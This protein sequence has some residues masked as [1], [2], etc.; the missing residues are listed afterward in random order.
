[1]IVKVSK[2]MTS[3]IRKAVKPYGYSI[4]LEKVASAIY[5]QCVDFDLFAHEKDYDISSNSFRVIKVVYPENMYAM[6]RYITSNDLVSIYNK[7]DKSYDGFMS[8]VIKEIE[9]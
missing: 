6:N 2:L 7:S 8:E 9:V 5:Q 3:A 1:M 4:S